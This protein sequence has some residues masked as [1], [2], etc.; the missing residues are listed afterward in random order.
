MVS[1]ALL[2]Q[3]RTLLPELI[4]LRRTLHQGPE[5]AFEEHLSSGH[6]VN[7]LLEIVQRDARPPIR[8]Q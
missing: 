3:A 2:D 1:V 7:R 6:D 5:P 4:Q 8:F